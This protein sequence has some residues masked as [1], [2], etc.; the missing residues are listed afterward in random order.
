MKSVLGK[1]GAKRGIATSSEEESDHEDISEP[2]VSDTPLDES[3]SDDESENYGEI[4][5]S[6]QRNH[7]LLHDEF[8]KVVII[9]CGKSH[10]PAV[11]TSIAN[12]HVPASK[13]A[14]TNQLKITKRAKQQIVYYFACA[15]KPESYQLI[16][17]RRIMPRVPGGQ[18]TRRYFGSLHPPFFFNKKNYI[19][20]IS[21]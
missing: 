17:S 4:V 5:G 18:I 14:L 20:G 12:V 15:P 2:E 1:G 9:E 13:I 19:V 16:P 10:F 7:P 11:L 3:D 6:N 21:H 8:T